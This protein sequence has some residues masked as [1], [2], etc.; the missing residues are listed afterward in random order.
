MSTT[1]T[2]TWS[3][4]E[5][6]LIGNADAMAASGQVN[7]FLGTHADSTVYHGALVN[8]F[9]ATGAVNAWQLPLTTQDAD[10]PFILSTGTTVGRVVIPLLSVGNGADL[11]VSLCQNNAGQPGAVITQTRI[12]A[13]WINQ[14]SAVTGIAQAASNPVISQYT[15]NPLAVAQF[16]RFS[17]GHPSVFITW[18]TAIN[19]GGGMTGGANGTSYQNY[20]VQIGGLNTGSVP[21][22]GV[23]TVFLDGAGGIGNPMSQPTFPVNSDGTGASIIAT[24]T[25]SGDLTLV[26]TGGS[27]TS[28]G[29]PNAGVYTAAFNN[30]VGTIGTWSAQTSLPTNLQNH[31]LATA[32]GYVYTVGGSTNGTNYRTDVSYAQVSNGQISAWTSG[33]PLPVAVQYPFVAALGNLLVVAGGLVVGGGQT[34]LVWYTSINPTTGVTGPWVAGPTMDLFVG[35]NSAAPPTVTPNGLVTGVGLSFGITPSGI[36]DAWNAST[37]SIGSPLYQG[38]APLDDGQWMLYNLNPEFIPAV[39][40]YQ[41]VNLSTYLSV[42][43]PASGLTT[44]GEYHILVQQQGGDLNDYLVLSAQTGGGGSVGQTLVSTRNA[45]TWS[46][47]TNPD[48]SVSYLPFSVFDNTASG[49]PWHMWEDNGARVSTMVWATTPDQRILGICEATEITT[50]L[51]ANTGFESGAIAPWT[52]STAGTFTASQTQAYEGLWSGHVVPTGSAATAA[53]LSER[54]PCQPGQTVVAFGR[55]WATVSITANYSLSV[56]WF[57]LAGTPISTS[58]ALVT[59]PAA[60]WTPVA[61]T[62][63]APT[64]AYFCQIAPTESGTPAAGHDFYFDTTF[65]TIPGTA[66]QQSSVTEVT[67]SGAWPNASWPITGAFPPLGSVTLA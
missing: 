45:Y 60:T 22:N 33:I 13:S 40:T 32:N 57:T 41:A 8:N 34:N 5:A 39:Y 21:T 30:A 3:A 56:N 28:G 18:P 48:S 49:P 67:W 47:Y 9:A 16:N 20:I 17:L 65:L 46:S 54:M 25:G 55:V 44:G 61:N 35:T 53:V 63:T 64:T 26:M 29:S 23:Y 37:G 58:S 6:K 12:P 62:Y 59:I 7:Q 24:E 52:N 31:G 43:L 15:G 42:P 10:A 36:A 2:P 66:P 14:L 19:V 1:I 4:A 51:N 50:A 38:M 27:T 11:L